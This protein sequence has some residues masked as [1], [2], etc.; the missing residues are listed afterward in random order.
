MTYLN[1]VAWGDLREMLK[2][3]G[4]NR[5]TMR[6]YNTSDMIKNNDQIMKGSDKNLMHNLQNARFTQVDMTDYEGDFTGF[7]EFKNALPIDGLNQMSEQMPELWPQTNAMIEVN[8]MEK[9]DTGANASKTGRELQEARAE[10]AMMEEEEEDEEE[11]DD[12]DEDEEEGE[13]DEEEGDEEDEDEDDGEEEEEGMPDDTMRMGV[14]ENR[15]MTHSERLRDRYNDV[16]LDSFMK[17]L[18]IKPNVQWTEDNTHHYK[19]GVHTYE[20]DSQQLDPY[21]HLIAEVERKHMER[22]QVIKFRQGSE[23]KF[24]VDPKKQA[25]YAR[26]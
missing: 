14:E 5:E 18:N 7:N 26:N 13:G 4:I 10:A 2:D 19:M 16:E 6:F 8:D 1:E 15:M 3:I 21:Y 23:V 25:K 20:D 22:Q 11:E 24:N 12:D 17:L 9:M